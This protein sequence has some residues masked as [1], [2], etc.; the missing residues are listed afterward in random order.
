MK[1]KKTSKA[2]PA[3][4]E[5]IGNLLLSIAEEMGAALIRSA[6]S[7]NIKERKDCSTAVFDAAGR[8][9]AQAEHI[10]MHLG[11][12]L[13]IIAE[14]YQRYPAKTIK[15]GDMFIANDPYHGGGTH[16]PD[17]TVAAPVFVGKKLMAWVAN[18]AHH[19]DVGG[20]VPGSTS[21]DAISIYQE[22]IRIPPVKFCQD[23]L[24]IR[25]IRDLILLN[26]RTPQ[27]RT[28]DLQAQVAAN[29]VGIKRLLDVYKKYGTDFD[30]YIEELLNYTEKRLKADIKKISNGVYYFKDYMDND[31]INPQKV[32]I[33]VEITVQEEHISFDFSRSSKQVTGPINVTMNG[34]Y[35]TVFYS[36]KALIDPDIPSNSG[37][38]RVFDLIVPEGLIVNSVAPAPVGERIDTCMRVVDVIIGAMAQAIPDRV[39]AACNGACTTGTFS[40]ID[41]RTNEFFVY[42][43]T[44]GGGLGASSQSDGMNGVQVHLTNT[45][46]LPI[47]ALEIEY[48][49]MVERYMLRQDSGGAGEYRGGLGIRRDIKTLAEDITFSALAD[50]QEIPP[51][52]LKGGMA[53]KSGAYYHISSGQQSKL[54]SKTS[55]QR[56]KQGDIIS[57]Q[58]PGSGGYGHPQ[59]RK[60]EA[61]CRDMIEGKISRTSAEKDYG[62]KLDEKF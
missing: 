4:I 34:L 13:T 3:T 40:G 43:E 62:V 20:K 10:P 9:V 57:I 35:A 56:L 33:A 1:G 58:T 28:G 46:N 19:S 52:G 26:C 49:L 54:S 39:I 44:I 42:L 37:I 30:F 5:I 2:D 7:S 45:S 51:W 25:E 31:G 8:M 22:G 17:I 53:G 38:Y 11:S 48:P 55:N 41:P 14:I 12:M 24:I 6:Y 32:P 16:L 23:G 61:V 36:L 29:K 21:G 59:E 47:E 18:I 60:K 50:R 15:E 27:E